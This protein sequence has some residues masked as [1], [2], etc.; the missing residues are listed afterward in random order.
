METNLYRTELPDLPLD[1]SVGS[2]YENMENMFFDDKLPAN[3]TL[4]LFTAKNATG[5]TIMAK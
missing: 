2:M 3:A 5:K 4:N 1:K